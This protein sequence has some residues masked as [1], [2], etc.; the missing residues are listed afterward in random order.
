MPGPPRGVVVTECR[1]AAGLSEREIHHRGTT[2]WHR[3]V[4]TAD[5]PVPLVIGGAQVEYGVGVIAMLIVGR[6]RALELSIGTQAQREAGAR[7]RQAQIR[8]AHQGLPEAIGESCRI[9]G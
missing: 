6:Q 1:S 8:L 5:A 9:D 4:G 7:I 2:L 3:L